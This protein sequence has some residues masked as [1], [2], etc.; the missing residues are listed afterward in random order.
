MIGFTAT[1]ELFAQNAQISVA[2][3]TVRRDGIIG[4]GFTHGDAAPWLANPLPAA[5]TLTPVFNAYGCNMA[6]RMAPIVAHGLRFDTSLPFYGWLEDVDFS[7]QVAA[8]GRFDERI[9]RPKDLMRCR[10]QQA[11]IGA[12]AMR[13]IGVGH[14]G[15]PPLAWRD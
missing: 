12:S 8:F 2:T 3:G 14:R 13:L 4:P 11:G 1:A 9:K 6:L 5:E 10:R 7:R 15:Q